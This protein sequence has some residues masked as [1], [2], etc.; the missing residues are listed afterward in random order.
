MT[1]GVFPSCDT[2]KVVFLIKSKIYQTQK[3][4]TREFQMPAM[5]VHGIFKPW[6][7]LRNSFSLAH[8]TVVFFLSISV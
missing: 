2:Q 5:N 3:H 8:W 7:I 6:S 4:C 1:G